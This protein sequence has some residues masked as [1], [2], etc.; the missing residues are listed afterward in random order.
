MKKSARKNPRTTGMIAGAANASIFRTA[1]VVTAT[2]ATT[3]VSERTVSP[4]A[5]VLLCP[6]VNS[7]MH[8]LYQKMAHLGRSPTIGFA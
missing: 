7:I 2:N 8:L 5:T 1:Q 3:S 4:V 6:S